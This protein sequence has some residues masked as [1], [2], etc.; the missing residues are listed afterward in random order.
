MGKF[1]TF[2]LNQQKPVTSELTTI[3]GKTLLREYMRLVVRRGALYRKI[4]ENGRDIYQI[5]LP[6]KFREVALNGAHNDMG[7][8]GRDRTLNVPR[9]RVYWPNM[10]ND[11]HNWVSY[12]DRCI[13]RETPA[14]ARNPLVN[15]TTTQPI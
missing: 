13:K 14:N 3:E 11:V 8:F 15:I 2:V 6:S 1:S 10:T 12:C 4:Q 5:V 9:E 7:H